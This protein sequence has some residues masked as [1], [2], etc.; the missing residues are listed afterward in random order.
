[1]ISKGWAVLLVA[2]GACSRERTTDE[3]GSTR[4]GAVTAQVAQEQH[5]ELAAAAAAVV[6]REEL[7]AKINDAKAEMLKSPAAGSRATSPVAAENAISAMQKQLTQSEPRAVVIQDSSP[8]PPARLKVVPP[9]V[10]DAYL[11]ESKKVDHSDP[12]AVARLLELKR[13]RFEQ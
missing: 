13:S 8:T 7:F 3:L 4:K 5:P 9:S 12:E 2:A 1:M 6:A 10:R 11:E